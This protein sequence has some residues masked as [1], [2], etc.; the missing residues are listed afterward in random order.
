M[1]PGKFSGYT[2]LKPDEN[3]SP[4][5]KKEK[6]Y[7]LA[8]AKYI[9]HNSTTNNGEM[10]YNAHD[11]YKIGVDYY[12]G[13]QSVDQYQQ[14]LDV[15]NK[16]G[17]TWTNLDWTIVNYATKYINIVIE[18]LNQLE[19]DPVFDAVDAVSIDEKHYT[20]SLIK[21]FMANAEFMEYMGQLTESNFAPIDPEYMPEDNDELQV[22]MD[23]KYKHA[24]AMAIEVGVQMLL[25]QSGFRE[26]EKEISM[27][28]ALKGVA[29]FR[30]YVDGHFMPKVKKG[31]I[32]HM[33]VPFSRHQD[34]R[35]V[36]EFAEIVPMAID[37]LRTRFPEIT[38]TEF[39]DIKEK[40]TVRLDNAIDDEQGFASNSIPSNVGKIMEFNFK[41]SNEEVRLKSKG[42][43]GNVS[44]KKMPF[45]YMRGK[46]DKF[47]KKFEGQ[48]EI[49]RK[50]YDVWYKGY[51]VVGSE[52]VFE[53]G[54]EQD[55]KRKEE[56]LADPISSWHICA[57]NMLDGKV[58]AIIDQMR[59]ILDNL[60]L[61]RLKVQ[62][63]IA[64]AIPKGAYIDLDALEAANLA[65]AGGTKFTPM[66][67]IDLYYKRGVIVGRSKDAA[68]NNASYKAIMELENGMAQDLVKYL[69]LMNSDLQTIRDM[70]GI[71]ELVDGSTPNPN[72][73]VST[74]KMAVAASNT[75]LGHLYRAKQKMFDSVC[76][77]LALRYIDLVNSPKSKDIENIVG[78]ATIDY[79]KTDKNF[80]LRKYGL[81]SMAR[82]TQ[83]Q[84]NQFYQEVLQSKEAG[85]ITTSDYMFIKNINNL[86]QAEL[87]MAVREKRR[88][89]EAAAA[90]QRDM[91][92]NAQIQ[93]QSVQTTNQLKMMEIEAEKQAKLAV[94]QAEAVRDITI[95]KELH[96]LEL[97]KIYAQAEAKVRNTVAMESLKR[98]TKEI[99]LEANGGVAISKEVIKSQTELEKEEMR[100]SRPVAEKGK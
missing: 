52:Y 36:T 86:K 76:D 32:E 18:K 37:T 9:Y 98:G 85:R 28:L 69:E 57:P 2:Y 60:Q 34:F 64:K 44:Y 12:Q 42:E 96:S 74:S 45:N 51:W 23:T 93:Q 16:D 48:R 66:E 17:N 90:A 82:P 75:A 95:G 67:L 61:N 62:D 92:L 94:I 55:M 22:Y 19:F 88:A 49:K 11:K 58:V 1:K 84:W 91:E 59:P 100:A 54:P 68:G 35:D 26:V 6:K 89:K 38:D 97:E 47:N 33:I 13:N 31:F 71:N 41:T 56:C 24:Y 10:F 15:W 70:T 83:E 99:E 80:S 30:D 29:C 46:E 72:Q 50:F 4:N 7:G 53:Y 87:V 77:S 65:G 21:T 20:E 39:D 14:R 73:P 5:E 81:K 8:M 79:L 25:D 3:K 27:D 43:K 63:I 78:K 40:H